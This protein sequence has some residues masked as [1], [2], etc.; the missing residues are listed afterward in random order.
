[1]RKSGKT[2]LKELYVQQTDHRGA[3]ACAGSGR[4]SGIRFVCLDLCVAREALISPCFPV[5]TVKYSAKNRTREGFGPYGT[6]DSS[7]C[8]GTSAMIR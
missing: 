5:K 7:I 8:C 6:D 2:F 1:M 4:L 3:L